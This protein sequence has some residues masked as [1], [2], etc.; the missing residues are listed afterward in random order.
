MDIF[1]MKCQTDPL[2]GDRVDRAKVRIKR[3]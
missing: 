2:D 1:A 3:D